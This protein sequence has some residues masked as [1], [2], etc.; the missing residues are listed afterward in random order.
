MKKSANA[1]WFTG[2][3][4]RYP[5]PKSGY[6]W[7]VECKANDT[8]VLVDDPYHAFVAAEWLN[9]YTGFLGQDATTR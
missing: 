3:Q 7:A 5:R 6:W 9:Y 1:V 2:T 4:T 8:C